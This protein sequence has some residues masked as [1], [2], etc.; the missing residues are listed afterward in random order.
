MSQYVSSLREAII[1]VSNPVLLDA[2]H[3]S[4]R[5]TFFGPAGTS[6]GSE[7]GE[8]IVVGYD[9][10]YRYWTTGYQIHSDP[11]V[12]RIHAMQIGLKRWLCAP[13]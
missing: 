1:V 9:V 3:G 12:H 4:P 8:W 2:I 10:H 11:E 6:S 13:Q 5:L 7:G